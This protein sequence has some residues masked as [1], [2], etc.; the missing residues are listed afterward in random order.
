M[1]CFFDEIRDRETLRLRGPKIDPSPP[2]M[3]LHFHSGD[4]FSCIRYPSVTFSYIR[5]FPFMMNP[6]GDP[7]WHHFTNIQLY[8]EPFQ[9][10]FPLHVN[11][12]IFEETLHISSHKFIY[13]STRT[14]HLKPFRHPFILIQQNSNPFQIVWKTLH[15]QHF[16]RYPSWNPSDNPSYN[17]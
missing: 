10:P 3:S 13:P 14:L 1:I 12:S 5:K 4:P 7:S 16:S 15:H 2:F 11:P 9:N 6:S 17:F 8:S